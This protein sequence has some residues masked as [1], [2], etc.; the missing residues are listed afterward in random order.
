MARRALTTGITGQDGGYLAQTLLAKGYEGSSVV[1]RSSHF[2]SADHRLRR[3][4]I[5]RDVRFIDANLIE[6]SSLVRAVAIDRPDGAYNLAAQS[7]V[8]SSWH[9]PILTSR[10]TSSAPSTC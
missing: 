6:L 4:G 10:V 8:T 5:E 7:F 3:L 2:G 9:R 1:R